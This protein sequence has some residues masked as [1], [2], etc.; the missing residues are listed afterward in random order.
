MLSALEGLSIDDRVLV[1]NCLVFTE[2]SNQSKDLSDYTFRTF[3]T[4]FSFSTLATAEV[5]VYSSNPCLRIMNAWLF[6]MMEVRQDSHFETGLIRRRWY[7]HSVFKLFITSKAFWSQDA[8][9]TDLCQSSTPCN[10]LPLQRERR[11]KA[12]PPQCAEFFTSIQ[13]QPAPCDSQD[14]FPKSKRDRRKGIRPCHERRRGKPDDAAPSWTS[15]QL[16]RYNGFGGYR[17]SLPYWRYT[18]RWCLVSLYR[19]VGGGSK[20]LKGFESLTYTEECG[21]K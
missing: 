13:H 4:A 11:S 21:Q 16:F 15:F 14:T 6:K 17:Q 8:S 5:N 2:G 1:V 9:F 20:S 18:S 19:K 10:P 12:Y 3:L 7:S